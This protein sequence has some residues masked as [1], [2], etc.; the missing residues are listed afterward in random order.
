MNHFVPDAISQTDT[1]SLL[2]SLNAMIRQAETYDKQKHLRITSLYPNPADSAKPY[3]YKCY[4]NLF[5]EYS[6]YNFDSAYAYGNKMREIASE[7]H[8]SS[9]VV[10]SQIEVG[11]VLLSSGLFKEAA[12]SLHS[13][14]I[15]W[16]TDSQ[17][18]EY[19]ILLAKLDY[20]LADYAQDDKYRPQ[21]I[22]RANEYIDSALKYYPANSFEYRYYNGLKDIREGK[23]DEASTYFETLLKDPHLSAHEI[24]LTTSTFSDIYI[25]AEQYDSAIALLV[26][27]SKAD[28]QTST[29]ET[30]ALFYLGTLLFKQGDVK[31]ATLYIHKAGSDARFYGARQRLVQLGAIL[32]MID[33]ENL[34]EVESENKNILNYAFIITSLFLL[35]FILT[36]VIIR[37]VRKL[38]R[39]QGEISRQYTSLQELLANKDHLLREK[40][41][42]WMELNHRVKNNLQI[43]ITLLNA[44]SSYIQTEEGLAVV[45]NSKHRVYAMSLL[46]ERLYQFDK[47]NPI[48]MS[49]YIHELTAY[50]L[51][52]FGMGN[53]I[54]V[55][56]DLEKIQLDVSQAL[57]LGLI[58]NE[59]ITNSI[60]YAFPAN[61]RGDIHI[62]MSTG[63]D[64]DIAI[65]IEDSGVGLPEDF[66]INGKALH[67]LPI[68]KGLCS[69]LNAGFRI[70]NKNGTTISINF[71]MTEVRAADVV[72]AR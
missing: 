46:H 38:K 70:E 15:R 40:E 2:R 8:D 54:L 20:S 43:I 5:N 35:L 51:A 6:I 27:A 53:R 49:V 57:P 24:A 62:A 64:G 56:L 61:M 12:D 50:L 48:D 7:L 55:R 63:L 11:F 1:D 52:S 32:P 13:S 33:R 60:K 21:Y 45:Q 59:A 42:L 39:Q 23:D 36:I 26:R 37:Q 71:I 72:M 14:D 69:D 68:I 16:L 4:L 18:K 65:T 31:N 34:Y 9:R 28:I 19:Y 44:Q 30:S 29:K 41:W 25:R 66:D 47:F 10:Y 22:A 17:K 58:I 3:L 67:G